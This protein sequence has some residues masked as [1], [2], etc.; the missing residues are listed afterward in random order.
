MN[1]FLFDTNDNPLI[2]GGDFKVGNCDEQNQRFLILFEKGS[3]KR[4]PTACVGAARYLEAEDPA[5]LMREIN[6]QLSGDGMD[7]RSVSVK[8]GKLNV[9]ASYV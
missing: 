7:V 9:E 5:D 4:I 3:I 2:A 6:I 8:E 1:D